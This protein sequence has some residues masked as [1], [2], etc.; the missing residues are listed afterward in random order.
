M[1]IHPAFKYSYDELQKGLD[2]AVAAGYVSVKE[3][4]GLKLYN[5]TPL[6]TFDKAWSDFTKI[7]RGLILNPFLRKIECL[8]F[9]KFFN[10]G[11]STEALPELS[12]TV[13]DKVD[14][15]MGL[16]Y[17]NRNLGTWKFATRGSFDSEQAIKGEYLFYGGKLGLRYGGCSPSCLDPSVCYLYEIVYPENR[18]VVDYKGSEH[19][20]LLGAYN[21]ETGEE[22]D[23]ISENFPF[24]H[25]H[26]LVKLPNWREFSS[27]EDIVAHGASIKG[28][29]GEGVV[30][31]Y[32]NG[33]RIKIKY[34]D[35]CR[36]HRTISR[37]TPLAIW[38][39]I[40]N[41]DNLE[42]VLMNIPEEFR[43]DF[44]VIATL[45]T[46][47][48]N[49]II[50]EAE[51]FYSQFNHLTRKD[52]AFTVH[53]LLGVVPSL[54]FSLYDGKKIDLRSVAKL[55]RPTGNV[56]AGYTPTNSMN[57]FIEES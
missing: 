8:G 15:S 17:Y 5:Y 3:K 46:Q 42:T 6:C 48:G 40:A 20:V 30:V 10:Y 19:L 27:I 32:S 21:R 7:A 29:E 2:E 14:G 49:A 9:P 38:E 51:K 31:R 55:I 52:Y 34:E 39:H 11:E 33:H 44:E 54:C 56:L 53:S 23:I 12:F 28:T 22:L 4:W 1:V 50:A 43:K 24:G 37:I 25:T 36:L 41:G 26:K 45:L 35:Y 18:I 16:C 13:T 47:R 57:R